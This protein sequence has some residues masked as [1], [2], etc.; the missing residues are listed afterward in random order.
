MKTSCAIIVPIYQEELTQSE[1]YS[2][3]HLTYYLSGNEIWVIKPDNLLIPVINFNYKE[4]PAKYF[5]NIQTYSQLLLSP[6]FYQAFQYY[7]Y[8]FIYQLDCLVFSKDLNIWLNTGYDYIGAPWF[9]DENNPYLGF[10]H[11]GNGGL[12]LRRVDAFLRILTSSRYITKPVSLLEDLNK[13]IY[14]YRPQ[15]NPLKRLVN[16]L[17]VLRSLRHGVQWYT[18]NYSLNEDRFWS[19]RAFFFDPDFKIAPVA[20]GLNFPSSGIPAT[21]LSK[22]VVSSP[23]VAMPGRSGIGLSG[24]PI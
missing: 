1:Q 2:L 4:F 18:A 24:N 10:S 7:E 12:S 3:N 16:R 6:A 8:L 5:L 23:L 20:D 22:M 11:V 19:D 14:E 17:R 13:P 15:P 9:N 21:V